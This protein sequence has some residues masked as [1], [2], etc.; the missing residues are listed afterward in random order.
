MMEQGW[1]RV[2]WPGALN[3]KHSNAPVE[4]RWRVG[5]RFRYSFVTHLL[6]AVYNV[7]TIQKLSLQQK[8][9]HIKRG[10]LMLS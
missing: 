5:C 3:R 9:G 10:V 7:R 6:E 8:N 4:W 1:G 2:L